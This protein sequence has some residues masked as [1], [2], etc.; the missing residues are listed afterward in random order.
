MNLKVTETNFTTDYDWI[1]KLTDSSG[2]LYYIMNNS[3]YIKN[4]IK[5]PLTKKELDQLDVGHS[6]R[7]DSKHIN[8]IN[9]VTSIF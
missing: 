5:S 3:F 8:D 4:N 6:L 1:F 7:C 2:N 9:L